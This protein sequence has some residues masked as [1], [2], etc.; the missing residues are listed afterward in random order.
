VDYI[1]LEDIELELIGEVMEVPLM[2]GNV[3]T[4]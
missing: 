4:I 3:K 2:N 1:E